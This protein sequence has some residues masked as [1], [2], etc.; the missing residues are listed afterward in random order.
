MTMMMTIK[1]NIDDK[2]HDNFFSKHLT[3]KQCKVARSC[4][5]CNGKRR[6]V[7]K[8]VTGSQIIL[9]I[10]KQELS[11]PSWNNLNIKS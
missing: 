9:L 3:A 5:L 1:S 10:S 8:E 6:K 11:K 4:L 7:A 2:Y